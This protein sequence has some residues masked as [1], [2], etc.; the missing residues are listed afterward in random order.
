MPKNRII[1][2]L[3][4]LI[5]LLPVLGFPRSWESFFQILSGLAIVLLSVWSTIDKKLMLKAK[6][7][8]RQARKTVTPPLTDNNLEE[9]TL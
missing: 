4:V 8:M 1:L 2:V 7:Q 6:A 3:G 9:P 5:A